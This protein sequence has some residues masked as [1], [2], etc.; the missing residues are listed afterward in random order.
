M[1]VIKKDIRRPH[2]IKM[3]HLNMHTGVGGGASHQS[4]NRALVC[5]NYKGHSLILQHA[6]L[7]IACAYFWPYQ[8]KIRNSNVELEAIIKFPFL[9]K[10]I[11]KEIH[12]CLIQVPVMVNCE[13]KKWC[14]KCQCGD[15]QTEEAFEKY[16]QLKLLT[17]FM[18]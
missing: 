11:P 17:M 7:Q 9:Q 16:H 12:E 2:L 14:A 3:F 10:K 13:K 5:R 6:N 18:T 4:T 1:S 15:F 8:L